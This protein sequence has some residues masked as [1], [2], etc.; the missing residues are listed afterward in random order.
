MISLLLFVVGPY[1][2]WVNFHSH[3]PKIVV[4]KQYDW[5]LHMFLAFGEKLISQQ[6]NCMWCFKLLSLNVL[7]TTL[8]KTLRVVAWEVGKEKYI[9][10]ESLKCFFLFYIY[11]FMGV[12]SFF[13]P[14]GPQDA[15]RQA[16]W[17]VP[18]L[19][20]SLDDLQIICK[21]VL[22]LDKKKHFRSFIQVNVFLVM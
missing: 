21:V 6:R 13:S 8:M 2:G 12:S 11:L 10:S 18:L 7:V 17:Q 22:F 1:L 5:Y 4:T 20:E 9:C 3:L 16:C 19:A 14:C 15:I